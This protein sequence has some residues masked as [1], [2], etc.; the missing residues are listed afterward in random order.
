M[1]AKLRVCDL[2]EDELLGAVIRSWSGEY[3]GVIY[4]VVV[5]TLDDATCVFIRWIDRG[6]ES[7]G[8]EGP[9]KEIRSE[10]LVKGGQ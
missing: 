8:F 6:C 1:S 2:Q 4:R 10:V 3:Q 9:Y 7:D 5:D